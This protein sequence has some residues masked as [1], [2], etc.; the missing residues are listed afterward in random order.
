MRKKR[1]SKQKK[2]RRTVRNLRHHK[3]GKY[4]GGGEEVMGKDLLDGKMDRINEK[5]L[6]A[7][8]EIEKQHTVAQEALKNAIT[9]L[10]EAEEQKKRETDENDKY[11]AYISEERMTANDKNL[12]EAKKEFYNAEDNFEQIENTFITK[13]ANKE[14]CELYKTHK[15]DLSFLGEKHV[16]ELSLGNLSTIVYKTKQ[17]YE[18][19]HNNELQ[20]TQ[21]DYERKEKVYKEALDKVIKTATA[22][23]KRGFLGLFRT[24][25]KDREALYKYYKEDNT[26]KRDIENLKKNKNDARLKYEKYAFLASYLRKDYT[27][28]VAKRERP[29]A[30]YHKVLDTQRRHDNRIAQNLALTVTEEE[31][32]AANARNVITSSE[33]YQGPTQFMEGKILENYT[34]WRAKADAKKY[35]ERG[36]HKKNNTKRRRR[37]TKK[38]LIMKRK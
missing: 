1:D 17:V 33:Q 10:T 11:Y 15:A 36:G 3:I 8:G 24:K 28:A 18:N 37:N 4:I 9:K 38:Q 27:D 32:K 7:F 34:Q 19:I 23:T 25:D 6:I 2:I 31:R 14:A 21:V 22:N 29:L 26:I 30:E 12:Y 16:S 13:Q 35:A 20:T 5:A